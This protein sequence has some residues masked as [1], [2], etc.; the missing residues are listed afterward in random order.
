MLVFALVVASILVVTVIVAYTIYMANMDPFEVDPTT[1]TATDT[2][3][4][5]I[6]REIVIDDTDKSPDEVAA[7]CAANDP[8]ACRSLRMQCTRGDDFADCA[9]YTPRPKKW[10]KA[11]QVW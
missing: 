2:A 9:N 10:D 4:P 1:N 6:R 3:T 8:I 5:A 11:F 7:M